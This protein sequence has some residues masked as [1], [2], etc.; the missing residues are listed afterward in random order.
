MSKKVGVKNSIRKRIG[1]CYYRVKNNEGDILSR[2]FYREEL[3][4]VSSK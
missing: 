1:T 2:S 4:L 3:N